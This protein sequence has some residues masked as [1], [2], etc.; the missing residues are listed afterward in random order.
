MESNFIPE[1][2]ENH[3]ELKHLETDL[4]TEEQI[5]KIYQELT[6]A[7][8]QCQRI[9][10]EYSNPQSEL[11]A[12]Q[13]TNLIS[14]HQSLLDKHHEFLIMSQN[15]STSPSLKFLAAHH[16]IPRRLWDCGILPCLELM[17]QKLPGSMEFLIRF[18]SISYSVLSLLLE[19]VSAFKEIWMECLGDLSRYRMGI[20]VS[21][22]AVR[23]TWVGVS[24]GWYSRYEQIVLGQARIQCKLA[25]LARPDR[26]RQLFYYTK[27]LVSVFPHRD[28]H[29]GITRLFQPTENQQIERQGRR[30]ETVETFIGTH[31]F[32]YEGGS[33]AQFLY[34]A[35]NFLSSLQ[36]TLAR[37]GQNPQEA[38][39]F[40]ATNFASV[41]QY[42]DPK[43]LT[44]KNKI[45]DSLIPT[46]SDLISGVSSQGAYLTIH[47]LSLILK[48]GG[49]L[50]IDYSVHTSLA[51]IWCLALS[52]PAMQ[53]I[54]T[55]IPWLPLVKS[56]NGLFRSDTDFR[57]IESQSFPTRH[58]GRQQLP[59]DFLIRG[60]IWSQQ[61]YP[62][63]FFDNVLSEE[64]WPAVEEKDT[65]LQRQYRC[66]WLAVRVSTVRFPVS[67]TMGCPLSPICKSLIP[68]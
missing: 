13:L 68:N 66:L 20:E 14:E 9:D 64:D 54:G 10:E 6:V 38:V 32:L 33:E 3:Q 2:I 37:T 42:G 51:F 16:Q 58:D 34:L 27:A 47:T 11:T 56:L 49:N 50:E 61:Y 19:N 21:S 15:P 26:L 18:I 30:D 22:M 62:P 5:Q 31:K 46:I 12:S 44:Q 43:I 29:E 59:E 39:Y 57:Y 45:S 40:I 7:E 23:E 8:E 60:H 65:I 52:H 24:Q 67:G 36:R 41:L 28:T 55:V 25:V 4:I 63:G 35:E 48:H 1:M 17:R 53:Q